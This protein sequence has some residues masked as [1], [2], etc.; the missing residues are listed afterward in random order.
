MPIT[1]E[2]KTNFTA[3]E[4]AP[5]LLGRSDL[6][7]Y[8]NGAAA[9]RNVLIAP[10]GGVSRRP[11]L[12]HIDALPASGRLIP[13]AFNTEQ[14][15]LILLTAGAIRVY[16]GG[17]LEATIAAPWT[18]AQV[19]QVA[20]TQSADTLLLTHPDVPPRKFLRLGIATWTLEPWTFFTDADIVHQPHFKFAGDAVTLTPSGTTGDIALTASAPVFA[21]GHEGVRLRVAGR[22]VEVTDYDSPT[23]VAARVVEELPSAD[24]TIDWTEAAF[25][26]VRGWPTTT[27]FHQ[28]RLVIG[29]SRDLPNRLFL[30]KSGD[31]FNFDLGQGLD[32]ESIAFS[33]LSD[34]VNT[35]RAVFS[36]QH[37]QVF[38]SGSEWMVTGDP[39]T[40]TS[41][42]VTR[43]TQIGSPTARYVPPLSVD[44]ATLFA[45]RNGRE[46]RE[47]IYTDIEQAYRSTDL[48]L[49][50]R[51][52]IVNPVDQAY[53]ALER[54]LYMVRADGQVAALTVYRAEGVS[55]WTL[56]HTDGA[57]RAVAV[58]GDVVYFLTERGGDFALE[59][60]DAAL[61]TDAGLT[62]EVT[63]P[64]D[65]WA[66]LGH[67]EGREVAIVA[68][69]VVQ[70]RAQVD[71]GAV[72]LDA[73]ATRVEIGLPYTH[74]VEPLPPAQTGAA[75]AGQRIRPTRVI[76]RVLDTPA[77]CADTGRGLKDI[78]L[79][80][81]GS[82]FALLDAVPEAVS[83]DVEV[84]AFGWHHRGPRPLWRVEQD[85]PLPCTL[86]SVAT[87]MQ[88]SGG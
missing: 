28:D 72:V 23:V 51:H 7:A 40:P 77:L 36:G 16:L 10:T 84:G 27:A 43:Q 61:N 38:T 76:F 80:R 85:M 14:T 55:A 3:G 18:A 75:G 39:L 81:I 87:M 62:G 26:A 70:P 78:P 1:R 33:L 59:Q 19:G 73:P 44:G 56:L 60:L 11:G 42:Q 57:A 50:S 8:D 48:A 25:S 88:V 49:L 13:F 12:R 20:W 5:D 68:D 74:I 69:G 82:A 52:I 67:L 29:G 4:V 6:R 53:D 15:Y 9:L 34:Q 86:L 46:L 65:T 22:E 41:I 37:L 79:R 63:T 54:I 58:V 17:A 24:A 35:I 31:L 30:S 71:G 66:G 45:A 2:L 21:Q 32:D 83:G 47:F 64:T